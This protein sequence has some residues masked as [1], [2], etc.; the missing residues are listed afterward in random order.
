MLYKSQNLLAVHRH[1][2]SPSLAA[3][4]RKKEDKYFDDI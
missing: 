1:I 3:L 4:T 2:T